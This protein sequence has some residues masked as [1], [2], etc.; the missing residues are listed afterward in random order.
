MYQL[1]RKDCARL[2]HLAIAMHRQ[3]HPSRRFGL[4]AIRPSRFFAGSFSRPCCTDHDYLIISSQTCARRLTPDLSQEAVGADIS[5]L[6]S[7]VTISARRPDA[8]T[9]A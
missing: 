1:L 4:I 7:A 6:A 3:R 2:R 9:P 8:E 5:R